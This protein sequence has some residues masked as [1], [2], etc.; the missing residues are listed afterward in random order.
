[1]AGTVWKIPDVLASYFGAWGSICGLLVGKCHTR[2]KLMGLIEME[3]FGGGK[4]GSL[5]AGIYTLF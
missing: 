3:D 1:M 2:S 4:S 5:P